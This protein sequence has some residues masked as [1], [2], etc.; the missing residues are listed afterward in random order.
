MEYKWSTLQQN[1]F[2]S[3]VHRIRQPF[4][5]NGAQLSIH[6]GCRRSCHTCPPGTDTHLAEEVE[7]AAAPATA[8]EEPKANCNG[9]I[10]MVEMGE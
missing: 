4:F 3:Q 2:G 1:S 8:T 6:E 5:P 10:N 9:R 7:T